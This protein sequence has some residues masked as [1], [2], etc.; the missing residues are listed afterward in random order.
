MYQHQALPFRIFWNH[1]TRFMLD[2]FK[3]T[4]SLTSFY[5]L[6]EANDFDEIKKNQGKTKNYII[7]I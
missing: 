2:T 5:D 7:K 1:Y 6:S 4:T 3:E